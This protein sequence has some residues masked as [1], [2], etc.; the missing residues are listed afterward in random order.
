MK[1]NRTLAMNG[2]EYRPILGKTEVEME[3][4]QVKCQRIYR[5]AKRKYNIRPKYP[6]LIWHLNLAIVNCFNNI[7]RRFPVNCASDTLCCSKDLLYCAS[8]VLSE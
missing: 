1:R 5:D 7:M 3:I 8:K 2:S 4:A 6:L